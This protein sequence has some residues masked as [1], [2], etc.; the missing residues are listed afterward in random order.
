[1]IVMMALVSLNISCSECTNCDSF[2]EEPNV[3]IRFYNL[4]D[5]TKRTIIIDSVNLTSSSGLRHFSDTTWE[6]R[7][8]L[9]M[10]NDISSFDL[11]Y[12]DTAAQDLYLSNNIT[13]SYNRAFIRRD[14]NYIIVECY[15]QELITDLTGNKLVCKEE[16]NCISN[17]AKASLYN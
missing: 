5:T 17:Y 12:R 3:I 1:M 4:P 10:H 6:F 13:F 11:V 9:D 2:A 14:D 7:F 8:P 16:D 15:L